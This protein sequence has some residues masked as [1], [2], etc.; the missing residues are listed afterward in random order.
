M[1]QETFLSI[2]IPVYNEQYNL[3]G[4]FRDLYAIL[5]EH[6]EWKWE[7]IVIEDGSADQTR[8]VLAGLVKQYPETQVIFHKKNQGYNQSMRDGMAKGSGKYVMYVGADEE[9]DCSELPSFIIPLLAG[10]TAHADVVLGVRWQRNAY[11]LHRFFLSVIYIFL[12][13]FLFKLRVNDYN[14]SQ[15]W[16][17][18]LLQRIEMKSGSL[19]M[20][21]EII[22]KAHDLN[23][24]IKEVP[25]NHRGRKTGR[26]SLN[27]RIMTHALWDAF[28]F[29]RERNSKQYRPAKASPPPVD[30]SAVRLALSTVKPSK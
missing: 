29:W 23:Y 6:P 12:L 18:E 22:I 26:S 16:S 15:V 13:N 28:L 4:V 17:R 10:G 7:V 20:L 14:W 11:K 27:L 24:R 30:S 8:Q 3:P 19:F 5:K 2:V 21:P 25:S 1:A 9:F